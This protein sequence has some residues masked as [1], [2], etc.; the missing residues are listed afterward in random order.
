MFQIKYENVVGIFKFKILNK[1]PK[2]VFH[3]VHI[4]LPKNSLAIPTAIKEHY[5]LLSNPKNK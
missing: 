2:K 3:S 4:Y 1:T 5:T